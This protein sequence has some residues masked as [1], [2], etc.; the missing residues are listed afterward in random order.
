MTAPPFVEPPLATPNGG[1][2]G[3]GSLF[4]GCHRTAGIVRELPEDAP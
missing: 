3:V 2:G 1:R 4:V